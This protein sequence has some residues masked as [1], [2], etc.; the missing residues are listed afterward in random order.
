M[1]APLLIQTQDLVKVYRMGDN[2][3]HALAGVSI[4]VERGEFVAVMGPSGRAS[5]RS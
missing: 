3:V 5:R 4:D 2:E 1:A